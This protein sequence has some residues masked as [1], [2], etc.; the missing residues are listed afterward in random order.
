MADRILVMADGTIVEQGTHQE[1]LDAKGTYAKL[2]SLH[3]HYR[4]KD[5]SII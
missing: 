4:M 1:L 5:M 2:F 3:G